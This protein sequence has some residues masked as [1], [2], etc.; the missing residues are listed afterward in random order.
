M[1]IVLLFYDYNTDNRMYLW[2]SFVAH[3]QH[4]IIMTTH[5]FLSSFRGGRAIHF[6][7]YFMRIWGRGGEEYRNEMFI[8]ETVTK[9]FLDSAN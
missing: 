2:N 4:I 6:R 8:N 1:T 3:Y 5:L 7:M 9:L